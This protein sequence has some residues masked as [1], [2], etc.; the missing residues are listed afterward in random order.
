MSQPATNHSQPD[1]DNH[2][3]TTTTKLTVHRAANMM[4][5]LT[6]EELNALVEDIQRN[7]QLTPIIVH[8][9]QIIDGRHRYWACNQLG[10]TPKTTP[11]TGPT[12][13]AAIIE[14]VISLNVQRRHLTTSQRAALAA[15]ALP[16]FEEQAAQRM[17]AGR[18]GLKSFSPDADFV[19]QTNPPADTPTN[20]PGASRD[21]VAKL[22][23]VSGR[24]VQYAKN[25]REHDRDDSL[26]NQILTGKLTIIEAARMIKQHQQPADCANPPSQPTVA[27]TTTSTDTSPQPLVASLPSQLHTTD[28]DAHIPGHITKPPTHVVTQEPVPP[29]PIDWQPGT[30]YQILTD[31]CEIMRITYADDAWTVEW[32]I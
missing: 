22:F 20:T 3:T 24:Y 27:H 6:N 26:F 16:F 15:N 30:T 21:H 32:Q 9:N 4:P 7:G 11:W 12:D 10:I 1:V 2:P 29:P 31:G 5:A 28:P 23:A 8:D 18:A 14:A 13:P 25:I 17:R 19:S